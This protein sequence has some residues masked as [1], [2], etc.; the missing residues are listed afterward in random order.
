MRHALGQWNSRD[1]YKYNSGFVGSAVDIQ[2][3]SIKTQVALLIKTSFVVEKPNYLL[4]ENVTS[5]R[6]PGLLSDMSMQEVP[7]IL[8]WNQNNHTFVLSFK[9]IAQL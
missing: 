9:S 3:H 7:V 8:W 2:I 4:V 1:W 5:L 6:F